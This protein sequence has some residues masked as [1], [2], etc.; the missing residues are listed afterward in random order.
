MNKAD[1]ITLFWCGVILCFVA[2][3]VTISTYNNKLVKTKQISVKPIT[4]NAIP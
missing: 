2:W 1:I 4:V 3:C